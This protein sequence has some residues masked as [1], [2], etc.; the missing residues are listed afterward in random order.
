[1]GALSAPIAAKSVR[2]RAKLLIVK[3]MIAKNDFTR[4]RV[5]ITQRHSD[6]EVLLLPAP[7]KQQCITNRVSNYSHH[8][9]AHDDAGL[10]PSTPA[11]SWL[12][13]LA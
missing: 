12:R 8:H 6:Y 1:M 3:V 5:S 11:P 4:A 9:T 7:L 13:R 10:G 2:S